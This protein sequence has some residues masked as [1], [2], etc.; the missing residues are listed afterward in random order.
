MPFKG[1]E[2]SASHA[3]AAGLKGGRR[4]YFTTA[5]QSGG[6][7]AGEPR[8]WLLAM[9]TRTEQHVRRALPSL[10]FIIHFIHF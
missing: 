9:A 6:G 3:T 7:A 8:R 2:P 4:V 1:T 10:W 5:R